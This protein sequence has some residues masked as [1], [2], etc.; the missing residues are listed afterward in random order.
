MKGDVQIEEALERNVTAVSARRSVGKGTA[1]TKAVL[2]PGLECA[3]TEGT[4]ALTVAM[5]QKTAHR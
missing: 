2:R 3:V 1:V 4:H 5:T